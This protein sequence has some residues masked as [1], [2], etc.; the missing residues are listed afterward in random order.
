MTISTLPPPISTMAQHLPSRSKLLC[1]LKAASSASSSPLI[2]SMCRPMLSA[3]ALT[4]AAPLAALRT[5]LVAAVSTHL[6]SQPSI[7]FFI[8][9]RAFMALSQAAAE[10]ALSL[11]IPSPRRTV[12]FSSSS[13][14]NFPALSTSTT[15]QRMELEPISMAANLFSFMSRSV[16]VSRSAEYRGGLTPPPRAPWT[17]LSNAQGRVEFAGHCRA[18]GI[19]CFPADL[20][21]QVGDDLPQGYAAVPVVVRI[22]AQTLQQVVREDPVAAPPFLPLLGEL[23]VIRGADDYDPVTKLGQI[24]YACADRIDRQTAV[25]SPGDI[26]G[27]ADPSGMAGIGDHDHLLGPDEALQ[28]R[29]NVPH[30]EAGGGDVV[31]LCI[32]G[33]QEKIV[34]RVG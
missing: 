5:A 18:L 30:R 31:I 9:E 19:S 23:L 14:L 11:A 7:I 27:L 22:A 2:T 21:R 32:V 13:T 1:A 29:F 34:R 12:S 16:Q 3:T 33:K 15:M 25:A 4:K 10:M 26:V 8:R 20:F 17:L 24:L 28:G 6:A